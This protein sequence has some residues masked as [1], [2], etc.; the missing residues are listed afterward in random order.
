MDAHKVSVDGKWIGFLRVTGNEQQKGWTSIKYL[1][2]LKNDN[3]IKPKDFPWTKIAIREIG[4]REF[5]ENADNPR[6]VQYL[7]STENISNLAKSNDETPW[8]SAFVNWCMEMSGIEGTN[9]AWA[10]HWLHWGEPIPKPIRGC[11][12]IFKRGSGGHVGFY[13]KQTETSIYVLG[14]NQDD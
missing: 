11:V 14:G 7:R 6:I 9:S 4:R 3:L 2:S 12:V 13:L 5:Y 8:C 1:L 10:R